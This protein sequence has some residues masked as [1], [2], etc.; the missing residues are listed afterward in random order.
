MRIEARD[1]RPPARKKSLWSCNACVAD[2]RVSYLF[3]WRMK[4]K[5]IEGHKRLRRA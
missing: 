2:W 1:R 3:C 4:G 5:L